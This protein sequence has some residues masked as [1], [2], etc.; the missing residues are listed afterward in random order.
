MQKLDKRL[1]A[2]A[3]AL[4]P[5]TSNVLNPAITE[6]VFRHRENIAENGDNEALADYIKRATDA[7]CLCVMSDIYMKAPLNDRYSRIFY[8]LLVKVLTDL[9]LEIP[10]QVP[11]KPVEL[12]E[13]ERHELEGLRRGI[14][15]AQKRTPGGH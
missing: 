6:A 12:S 13:L 10:E 8:Y 7:E 3:R 15:L 9:G 1:R 11:G 14:R 4:R 2:E 5:A